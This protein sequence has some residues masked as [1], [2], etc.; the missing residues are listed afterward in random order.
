MNRPDRIPDFTIS[1]NIELDAMTFYF[2]WGEPIIT[3]SH[4]SDGFE[5]DLD[6]WA[7]KMCD[8]WH[9]MPYFKKEHK[10]KVDNAYAKWLLEKELLKYRF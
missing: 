7:L 8:T 4:F 9:K 6:R 2:W 10:D 3:A 1:L 5:C